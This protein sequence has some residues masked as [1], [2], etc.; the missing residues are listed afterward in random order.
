MHIVRRFFRF[1]KSTKW[2]TATPI[3]N[4]FWERPNSK[5]V[6]SRCSACGVLTTVESIGCSNC[7]LDS[8]AVAWRA[9]RPPVCCRLRGGYPGVFPNNTTPHP[10][11]LPSRRSGP[12]RVYRVPRTRLGGRAETGA[13]VVR[14]PP[15]HHRP[16]D[17]TIGTRPRHSSAHHSWTPVTTTAPTVKCL[18]PRA[19]VRRHRSGP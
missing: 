9:R 1:S 15:L 6:S 17:Q 3:L 14:K 2:G 5:A 16:R 18:S 8:A 11:S 12:T 10:P 7:T 13:T 4:I 19:Y